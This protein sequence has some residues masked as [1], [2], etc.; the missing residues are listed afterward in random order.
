LA[1][2]FVQLST[3]DPYRRLT[4]ESIV[5]MCTSNCDPHYR[6]VTLI[7]CPKQM[8]YNLLAV[9]GQGVGGTLISAIFL[10]T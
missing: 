2:S 3:I 8:C 10:V 1:T 7:P 9:T 5:V 4:F 6:I